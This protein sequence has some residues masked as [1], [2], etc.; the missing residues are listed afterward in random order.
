MLGAA[1]RVLH[2]FQNSALSFDETLLALNILERSPG[3]LL[4]TLDFNQAAPLGYLMVTKGSS[5][6]FGG[7]EYAL[8]LPALLASLGSLIL[9]AVASRRL[10][11][12][13]GAVVALAVFSLLDPLVYYSAI[14]KPY[15]FDVLVATAVLA[16]A[17]EML[18]TRTTLQ[19][20]LLLVMGA[21]AVAVVSYGALLILAAL[22][23]LLLLREIRHSSARRV[24]AIWALAAAILAAVAI[25]ILVSQSGLRGI[26]RSF[27]TGDRIAGVQLLTTQSGADGLLTD[28]TS[29]LRYLVGLE[30][31]AP[32]TPVLGSLPEPVNQALTVLALAIVTAGFVS[33]VLRSRAV[34]GLVALP[35]IFALA[36]SAAGLYPLV[37]R[38]LLFLLP[39]IGLCIGEAAGRARELA[40]RRVPAARAGVVA[41]AVGVGAIAL[42]PAQHLLRPR[43]DEEMRS[44]LAFIGEH[45]RSGDALYVSA[46]SQYG[47]AY[48]H[49]CRCAPFDVAS[50]WPFSIT[51]GRAQTAPA[52][53]ASS[54]LLTAG[55]GAAEQ[56]LAAI[57]FQN[58]VWILTSGLL[59]SRRS[60][61]EADLDARG[62]RL[63][64]FVP[65]APQTEAAVAYLYD[66]SGDR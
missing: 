16:A 11:R 17:P 54:P 35:P 41:V 37:G 12:P 8:R 39:S 25:P 56:E 51:A 49:L 19:N 9:F 29:R 44:P 27:G 59:P 64:T 57:R 33:L 65:D 24:V 10:L 13:T 22:V 30:D 21:I 6:L 32:G 66:F 43:L 7:S 47:V 52:I 14:A 34:A 4:A 46:E 15:A 50:Q 20:S 48:Y 31:T 61:L 63:L 42:L 36:A 23:T 53:E 60:R 62:R 2:Y 5:T 40:S 18:S 45:R 58:R 55:Q 3:E 26:Q 1:L 38:T 28:V